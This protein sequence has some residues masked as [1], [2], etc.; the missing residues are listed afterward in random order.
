[1]AILAKGLT[2][3]RVAVSFQERRLRATVTS[4][5]GELDFELDVDLYDQVCEADSMSHIYI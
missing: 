4:P 3:E 2:P 1:M 5:E